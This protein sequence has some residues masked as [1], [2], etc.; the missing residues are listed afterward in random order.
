MTRPPMKILTI[1]ATLLLPV[2]FAYAA[3]P[4]A[5]NFRT[6]PPETRPWCYWYWISDNISKDGI[7]RDLEAMARIGIGQ[8]LIGNVVD[9]ATPLGEVKIFS[10]GW[11]ELTEHA[12]R[13]AKRTGVTLGLFNS[14]GWS[15]SGGPW[16]KPGQAMRY[17]VSSETRVTGPRRF[18]AKLPAPKEIFQDVALLAFPAPRNDGDN[19]KPQLSCEPAL[20]DAA[21]LVDGDGQTGCELPAKDK[22]LVVTLEAAAPFTARSL[23]LRQLGGSFTAA[24][25]LAVADGGGH[26]RVVRKFTLD[27]RG[28]SRP[29]Y[30]VNV[31]PMIRG[32]T[33][34]S[35]PAVTAQKFRLRL[36][37]TAV[38]G[39][40]AGSAASIE[41][42]PSLAEIEL[43]GAARL[44][45][46]VEKQLGKMHP[47]PSPAW[48]SYVW[49][50][51]TEPESAAFTVAPNAVVNL[52]STL[53]ADG[54][55]T[56]DV[57]AGEW[58][59]LRT[60][61][62]PTGAHNH[63][64]TEEGSGYEVDK[65]NRAAIL[66]HYDAMVGKLVER[67]PKEDRSALRHV[68]IDS[69]EVGSQNWTDG[70]G[71]L[72]RQTYGYDATP[73]LPVLTGRIVGSANQSDRFLWD[74]RRLVADRIAYD[75]VGGLR[76]AAHRH[77]LRLWLENYGH[78]GFPAEFL[79]YGGQ[80]D[81][82]GGEFWVRSD[83][84]VG[85]ETTELR[86]ASSAAHL[87]GKRVVFAE[88]F[89]SPRS[90][91]DF[92]ARMKSLGDWAFC[93]GINHFIF[94]VY[95]QQPWE[96]RRPGI[97]AWFGTEFN[98]HNTWF[99][100]SKAWIDYLR[101]GHWMLQQG[102]NVADV[103]YFIGEDAPKMTGALLPA[104]PAGHDFDFINAEV[105]LKRASV[106]G[107][108]LAIPDGPAY[109]V[110]VLPPGTTMRPAV[111]RRIRDLAA[112][113]A[114]I[115]GPAPTGSP[116]LQDFPAADA[117]VKKLAAELWG[118]CDGKKRTE[119]T[120][121][122]GRVFCGVELPEVFRHLGITPDLEQPDNL[123]WTH[124][125]TPDA[126][127]YFVANPQPTPRLTTLSFRVAGRAPEIWHADS[128]EIEPT[129][130][131][132]AV[133]ERTRVTLPLDANGAAFVVFRKAAAGAS[134]AAVKKDGAAPAASG[135]AC[136]VQVA[137]A[138]RKFRALV[139][140]S[141]DY[142][143]TQADGRE[144]KLAARLP[145]PVTVTGGW[146][147]QFPGQP[148]RELAELK[149]W[150]HFEDDAV[151]YFSGTATYETT[152]DLPAELLGA[153][154][155]LTLDLGRVDVLAEVSL[156]GKD[157]GVAW[158]P[159]FAVDLTAAAKPGRNTLVVKVTNNWQ[160][161]L[162]G[163]AKLPKS[164][165]KTFT[166]APSR[167]PRTQLLPSGLSGPVR[168]LPAQEFELTA[169]R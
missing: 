50:A 103:A 1:V 6:P 64:T 97:N 99:N 75:Y 108:R 104:L 9:P 96:D 149:P 4:L 57:P 30:A 100:Q 40:L 133:G 116:S 137:R 105:L 158:K 85:A 14:P 11:W 79:Q 154:R 72:F 69:Y 53:A 80:S 115:L 114:T 98:R 139:S 111:L 165:R 16:V 56:W 82:L 54:T 147:L 151:K 32:A 156:N 60:G 2:G 109:R 126:D 39:A 22:P 145:A 118:D 48:N 132:A 38:E 45:A 83:N 146:K 138:G 159:P 55:L 81:D 129:A 94:H 88:A 65:M 37:V 73:W 120:Y 68:V 49:P 113:G 17:L 157:L 152:L 78:W 131:F 29:L 122:Q 12:V 128:G 101:R 59:I 26:F 23:T 8:A 35:F 18:S 62:A 44:D 136:P 5:D 164:E 134:I 47:T 87:Y 31:G 34:V 92:P 15:Q 63:P 36:T 155:R 144:L 162:I 7:T 13:E 161:R 74:L 110:L 148:V 84:P 61:M 28:L 33:V 42:K 107:G 95:I 167:V 25:E 77:G 140:E 153:G 52:T 117:E 150:Q 10:P 91:L 166:T 43:S 125:Q 143:F 66:A 127:I 46:N 27:R 70:F 123:N 142:A 168:L 124:R 51:P 76:D 135:V 67:M 89:T 19:L 141:G 58:V 163:D 90:F 86:A 119:R 41:A 3:D 102:V 160:N 93:Q 121:G 24:G 130:L 20:A 112:A 106:K 21:K 169:G 71:D